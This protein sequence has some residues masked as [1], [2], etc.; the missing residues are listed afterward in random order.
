MDAKTLRAIKKECRELAH[1]L[2]LLKYSRYD[3]IWWT[4]IRITQ[5]LY[6][7]GKDIVCE[8]NRKMP[9]LL[10]HD[11][12]CSPLDIITEEFG[13][14]TPSDLVDYLLAYRPRGE[15]KQR[16]YEQILE[17]RLAEIQFN[18]ENFPF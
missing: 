6:A 13:F 11:R 2:M 5:E 9:N 10:T 15:L 17:E 16:L 4:R 7:H 1:E 3:E 14:E 12:H 18:E 8:I